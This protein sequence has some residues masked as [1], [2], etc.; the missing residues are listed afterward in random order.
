MISQTETLSF[1]GLEA[2]NVSVQAH[3]ASGLAR[4]NIVGLADKTVAESKERIFAAMSSLG[5][6][7]PMKRITVNLSPADVSKEGSH[8]DL[9]IICAL[10]ISMGA[11]PEEELASFIIL[12]ELRL[13]GGIA[14]VPGILPATYNAHKLGKGIL[15]PK[16]NQQE[17]AWI[18][19]TPIVAPSH[20]IELVNHFNNVALLPHPS[21]I[22]PTSSPSPTARLYEIKGQEVA[23]RALII[24]AAGGHNL[25]MTGPPGVGKS[26]LASRLPFLLPP[27]TPQEILESSMI[28]SIAG[29]LD[30]DQLTHKRPFRSPHHSC[31]VAAMVGGG[32]GRR[33]NPGEVTLAHNGILFL[34]ELP[35][36][37]S[38]ALE[39]LRQ[40]LEAG[41]VTIAR[42]HAHVTYP[43]KFQ[44]I[45]A[46]NPCRCGYVD[47]PT[48]SCHRA[49][50]CASQYQS[51]I[52]GPLLDRIDLFVELTYPDHIT[53][54]ETPQTIDET[55]LMR[56]IE[57]A[58]D[59]Q[60]KRYFNLPY[61]LNAHAEENA[62]LEQN[63]LTKSTQETLYSASVKLNLS[64]RAATRVLRVAR[65]IADLSGDEKIEDYHLNEALHYRQNIKKV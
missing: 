26:M 34:D 44:L 19:N 49:P 64:M 2:Q 32:F 50:R 51:S 59:R 7:L 60:N 4:F 10:L 18:D 62:L 8:F 5:L 24:A 45:A 22:L 52:S 15:C 25:L 39:S 56:Q 57:M 11:L 61:T 21:A 54:Y 55:A 17:A 3:M 37:P 58:R 29:T 6:S 16:A 12:G 40:P 35:E 33:T 20:L 23:K 31:S 46:M 9:P 13:D 41:Q 48:R 43:A 38:S 47:D 53:R 36:F 30:K 14:S 42:A 1:L 63:S 28:S 27:L 65:T